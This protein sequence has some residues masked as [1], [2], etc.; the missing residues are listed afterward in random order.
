MVKKKR[1]IRSQSDEPQ[2]PMPEPDT[3]PPTA[4]PSQPQNPFAKWLIGLLALTILI[5]GGPVA[6]WA[7]TETSGKRVTV[8]AEQLQKNTANWNLKRL[9]N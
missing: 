5:I 8:E 9:G 6:L 4:A 3:V 7:Q 2:T 1:G